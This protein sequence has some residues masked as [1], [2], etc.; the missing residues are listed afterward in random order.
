[1]LIVKNSDKPLLLGIKAFYGIIKRGKD[2]MGK[3][4]VKIMNQL[5]SVKIFDVFARIHSKICEKEFMLLLCRSY[6]CFNGM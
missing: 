5:A 1:M 3:R 2:L 6:N 4:N